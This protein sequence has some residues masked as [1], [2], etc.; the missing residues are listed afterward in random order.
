MK[1]QAAPFTRLH[2]RSRGF[3]LVSVPSDLQLNEFGQGV[4]DW[5][6]VNA[7]LVGDLLQVIVLPG[8]VLTV[9]VSSINLL[10][11]GVDDPLVHLLA[12]RPPMIY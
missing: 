9:L 4:E 11:C 5:A 7:D 2:A 6:G 3:A 12:D 1:I 10:A 8:H